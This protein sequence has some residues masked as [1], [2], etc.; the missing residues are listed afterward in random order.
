LENLKKWEYPLDESLKL[1]RKFGK[2]EA[3][4]F[5]LER[6]GASDEALSLY[7]QV[8]TLIFLVFHNKHWNL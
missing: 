4:A 7:F 3:S 6:T 2:N 8:K 5:L 1:C